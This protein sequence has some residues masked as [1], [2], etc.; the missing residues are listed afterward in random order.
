MQ[1]A[2]GPAIAMPTFRTVSDARIFLEQAAARE[3]SEDSYAGLK[4]RSGPVQC[5]RSER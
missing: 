5:D 1:P 4:N 2:A 3:A